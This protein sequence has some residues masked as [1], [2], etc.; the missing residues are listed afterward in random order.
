MLRGSTLCNTD[1]VYGVVVYTG[2]DTKIMQNSNKPQLKTSNVEKMLNKLIMIVFGLQILICMIAA[3][4]DL[5]LMAYQDSK[6]NSYLGLE[7]F[8][9]ELT[10]NETIISSE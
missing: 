9:Q 6:L 7:A 4:L 5:Y 1:W 2:R 8:W 3:L 10:G